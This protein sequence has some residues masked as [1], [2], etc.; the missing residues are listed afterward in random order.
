MSNLIN[1]DW[2]IGIN[3][4]LPL[5][6]LA[7]LKAPNALFLFWN[8]MVTVCQKRY[9]YITVNSPYFGSR[10]I[11]ISVQ[12]VLQSITRRVVEFRIVDDKRIVEQRYI[13]T[14]LINFRQGT[15]ANW[16]H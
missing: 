7:L 5:I 16:N 12:C 14:E 3:F 9:F 10:L 13:A 8:G 11:Q 15:A 2:V 6:V 1:L 4:L